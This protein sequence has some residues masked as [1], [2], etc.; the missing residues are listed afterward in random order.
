MLNS[1]L[2]LLSWQYWWVESPHCSHVPLLVIYTFLWPAPAQVNFTSGIISWLMPTRASS[3]QSIPW[4]ESSL[5]VTGPLVVELIFVNSHW[6]FVVYPAANVQP[7][8]MPSVMRLKH[9]HDVNTLENKESTCLL[10]WELSWVENQKGLK[11]KIW[12]LK[13]VPNTTY[14][15]IK[16]KKEDKKL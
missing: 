9:H 7:T 1:L 2:R 8:T 11:A 5:M 16:G 15:Q 4:M 10:Y 6:R 12:I 14:I 13:Y 3:H